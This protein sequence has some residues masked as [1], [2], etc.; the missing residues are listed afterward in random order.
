M[1]ESAEEI[2]E[3]FSEGKLQFTYK[4]RYQG[5]LFTESIT[6]NHADASG[7]LVKNDI[8]TQLKQ[9]GLWSPAPAIFEY[10]Q[11]LSYDSISYYG[12]PN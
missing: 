5:K 10:I 8:R 7:F 2:A 11:R 6:T 12:E 4:H 3:F 1:Y 9:F